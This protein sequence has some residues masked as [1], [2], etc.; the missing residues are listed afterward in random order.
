[1]DIIVDVTKYFTDSHCLFSG[2]GSFGITRGCEKYFLEP[3]TELRAQLADTETTK[4][5][6][7]MNVSVES[8]TFRENKVVMSKRVLL[9][10]YVENT[11]WCPSSGL[12]VR[13]RICFDRVGIMRS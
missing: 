1:M 2:D 9:S 5:E 8:L 13:L 4:G 12:F 11:N 3:E 6:S 10:M 7:I